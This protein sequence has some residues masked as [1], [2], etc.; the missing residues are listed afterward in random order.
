MSFTWGDTVRVK[1]DAPPAVRPGALGEVVGI[2]EIENQDQ[3]TQF[4]GMPL[5]TKLYLVELGDGVA[6]EV[7]ERM[8]EAD[9]TGP[10]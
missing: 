1:V 7:P 9:N 3:S 2:R 10:N 5:G 8:L 6:V 4:W